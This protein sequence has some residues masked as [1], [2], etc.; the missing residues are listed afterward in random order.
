ML[1][2][3]S[4]L[5]GLAEM[6]QLADFQLL[7]A[8]ELYLLSRPGSAPEGSGLCHMVSLVAKLHALSSTH[9]HAQPSYSETRMRAKVGA[10]ERSSAHVF[11]CICGYELLRI[12]VV[13]QSLRLLGGVFNT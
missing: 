9:C 1:E 10:F 8:A 4:R 13:H 2:L 11:Q 5:V 12:A 6:L 7:T 3:T